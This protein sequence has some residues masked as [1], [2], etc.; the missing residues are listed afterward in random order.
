MVSSAL[1]PT[2]PAPCSLAAIT[3]AAADWSTPKSTI[4]NPA[5]SPIIHTR[6]LPIS[7]KSPLTVPM[8]IVA[9]EVAAPSLIKSGFRTAIPAFMARAAIST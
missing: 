7:C 6:F 9:V 3:K 5:P 4:L 2:I 8:T 1:I